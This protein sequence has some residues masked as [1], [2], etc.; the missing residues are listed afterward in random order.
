M[1]KIAFQGNE[2]AFIKGIVVALFYDTVIEFL[3]PACFAHLAFIKHV[4][5]G[6]DKFKIVES[7][8]HGNFPGPQCIDNSRGKLMINTVEM[9]DI[10]REIRKKAGEVC[11]C[12]AVV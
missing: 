10:N 12:L 5:R 6:T 8:N 4:I 3:S 1:M 9:G 7:H 2:H 11:F